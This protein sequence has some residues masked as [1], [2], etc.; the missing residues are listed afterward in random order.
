[1]LIHE[2]LL[3][4]LIQRSLKQSLL[5]RLNE[6]TESIAT[7]KKEIGN[8]IIGVAQKCP[9]NKLGE[10]YEKIKN[11]LEEY[12]TGVKPKVDTSHR[13]FLGA[14]GIIF[15]V[16][17]RTYAQDAK[18]ENTPEVK[19]NFKKFGIY[20]GMSSGKG[21]EYLNDQKINDILLAAALKYRG[22]KFNDSDKK[23]I[24]DSTRGALNIA[25]RDIKKHL[26]LVTDI[27]IPYAN[28]DIAANTSSAPVQN[29]TAN[30]SNARATQKATDSPTKTTSSPAKFSQDSSVSSHLKKINANAV[31][32]T[33]ILN[34]E[35]AKMKDLFKFLKIGIDN[36]NVMKFLSIWHGENQLE[37]IDKNYLKLKIQGEITI[38]EFYKQLKEK[39]NR[40]NPNILNKKK[41]LAALFA[42]ANNLDLL[43]PLRFEKIENSVTTIE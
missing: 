17:N 2:S 31:K 8:F 20:E 6:G 40:E 10:L 41:F 18:G 15:A 4:S 38:V 7:L 35:N 24:P 19:K 37:T 27:L 21:I 30:N 32:I 13:L 34:N 26:N 33:N 23:A 11:R 36:E 1:M 22:E 12:E 16:I 29:A 5:N 25:I 39:V 28:T 42:F 3:K 14:L 9:A 43:Q